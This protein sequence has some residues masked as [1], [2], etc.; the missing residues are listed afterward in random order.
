MKKYFKLALSIVFVILT[1]FLKPILEVLG[2]ET[3]GSWE[4]LYKYSHI[5]VIVGIAWLL[6]ELLRMLKKIYFLN[7]IFLK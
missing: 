1:F 6:I 4:L 5:M 3:E 2:Y 7:T